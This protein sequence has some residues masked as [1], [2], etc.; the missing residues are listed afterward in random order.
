MTSQSSS[1]ARRARVLVLNTGGTIGM[2]MNEDG[3][4]AP[5]PGN[6]EQLM[7]KMPPFRSEEMPA[8]TLV[9]T[10]PLIDSAEMT[11]EDWRRISTLIADSYDDHDGFVVVH[12]T[13]TMAYTASAL[14][15]MLENL[16]KPVIL[17]GSQVP[18]CELRNDARE[19]LLAAIIIAG[20]FRIPE[21]C[22]YFNDRLYRGCRSVKVD[23]MDFAA[24]DSP[25]YPPLVEAGVDITVHWRR[26]RPMPSDA[27]PL[28]IRPVIAD[29]IVGSLRLFPG[30]TAGTVRNILRPPLRGLVLECYGV[31]NGP[32][33]NNAL[34]SAI[35]EATRRGTI[36]VAT[37]QCVS[38]AV[39]LSDYATG[40]ALAKAG[41]ISGGDMTTEAALAKLYHLFSIG[42][43]SGRVA[44]AMQRDL[45]GEVTLS[46]HQGDRISRST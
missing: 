46:R 35:A 16:S 20:R 42:W 9:E 28:R 27:H 33:K 18:L 34:I 23:A 36:V 30:I 26:I 14:P 7:K 41:V 32:A 43:T 1:K 22:I 39:E 12:G 37:S 5:S 4:Y 21:V 31:G 3:V 38:G 11:P 17:T 40:S 15:F 25:D 13:D 6:L 2:R 24:F 29:P 8:V 45:V 44:D 10:D 19:N